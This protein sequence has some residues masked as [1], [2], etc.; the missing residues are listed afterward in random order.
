M[1]TFCWKAERLLLTHANSC[2]LLLKTENSAKTLLSGRR[3]L[4]KIDDCHFSVH[5]S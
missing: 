1:V 2:L 4:R 5:V 3:F